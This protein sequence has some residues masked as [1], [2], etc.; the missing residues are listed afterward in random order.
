[1][2]QFRM[3]GTQCM[4][5]GVLASAAAGALYHA[6]KGASPSHLG[7]CPQVVAIGNCH[8]KILI[9]QTHCLEGIE[10]ADWGMRLADIALG[11]VEEGIKALVS[12][13]RGR[14]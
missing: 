4:L 12:G 1:M 9:E 13:K 7:A 3:K 11:C 5:H 6:S 8:G 14:N 2:G 10:V